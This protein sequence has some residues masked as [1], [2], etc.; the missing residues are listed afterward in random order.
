MLELSP[1]LSE[2]VFN[3]SLREVDKFMCIRSS[4]FSILPLDLCACYGYTKHIVT[5]FINLINRRHKMREPGIYANVDI[6]IYHSEE[7]ISSTG[8]NLI[9]DCPKRFAYE[10]FEKPK[11]K[12][13]EA[14]HFKLGRALHML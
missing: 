10:K 14:E 8:I 1:H 2:N 9:L 7:G 4:F 6:D 5:H 11:N 12:E 3:S 13:S